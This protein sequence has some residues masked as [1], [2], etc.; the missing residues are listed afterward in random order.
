M[1]NLASAR[2]LSPTENAHQAD[3]LVQ[4]FM[5]GE[6]G[7]AYTLS[8]RNGRFA[9]RAG[10]GKAMLLAGYR[11]AEKLGFSFHFHGEYPPAKPVDLRTVAFEE[12]RRPRFVRRGAQL[13]NFWYPG[14]D[15]W[16]LEDYRDYLDQFPKLGLNHLD[17]PLYLYEPLYT[18]Y[19]FRDAVQ[20]GH[21]LSGWRTDAVR[22]GSHWFDRA[23]RFSSPDVPVFGEFEARS[24]AMIRLT[25]RIFDHAESR[26]VDVSLGIEL[27]QPLLGAH[28]PIDTSVLEKIPATDRYCGGSLL[29]PSSATGKEF[30]EARL[31]ALIEAYPKC[32]LISVWKPEIASYT[33]GEVSPHPEDEGLRKK[34][35]GFGV[36]LSDTD[37]DFLC[38]VHV[39]HGVLRRLAPNARMMLSGWGV[40][41]LLEFAD[42]TL[43]TDMI[44]H[45]ID[46][47]EAKWTVERNRLDNYGHTK[48]SKWHTTWA[49][50]D[51]QMWLTQMKTRSIGRLLDGLEAHDVEGVM[52][53]HWR[54][55]HCDLN[56]TFLARRCWDSGLMPE[57]HWR[58]WTEEK[59]G[60]GGAEHIVAALERLE[61]FAEQAVEGEALPFPPDRPATLGK[62]PGTWIVGQDCVLNGIYLIY[63]LYERG[64][65]FSEAALTFFVHNTRRGLERIVPHLETA[66]DHLGAAQSEIEDTGPRR[67]RF[68]F[69]RNRIDFTLR[70][71]RFHYAFTFIAERIDDALHALKSGDAQGYRS[72]S[73]ESLAM[74]RAQDVDGLIS[75]FAELMS[76]SPGQ[77]DLGELGLLLGLNQKLL[78]IL[79]Q[80]R[81]SLEAAIGER[82]PKLE[83]ELRDSL[84]CIRCA[85]NVAEV[86]D[87]GEGT[88][89]IPWHSLGLITGKEGAPWQPGH[90]QARVAAGFGYAP[91]AG[92]RSWGLTE[93]RTCWL[94]SNVMSIDIQT[95]KDFSGRLRLH[96][97][98]ML[99]YTSMFLAQKVFVN[100]THR[101]TLSDCSHY[102]EFADQ[103][104]WIDLP[105]AAEDGAINIR[106][107]NDGGQAVQGFTKVSALQ[108]VE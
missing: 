71:C 11:L 86:N 74:L 51:Q 108:L 18:N 44:R 53:V 46:L 34:W 10:S 27:G 100:G 65:P 15:S 4:S 56:A 88:Y 37:L 54:R 77:G 72:L 104:R 73:A 85:A 1:M 81:G 98:D 42:S 41:H 106:I 83:G 105:V 102:G 22:I 29:M 38:W 68:T 32:R 49:E 89:F 60:A 101:C 14:R 2:A 35:S 64:E 99:G 45:S 39:A 59:F 20:F 70:Y 80:L 79:L 78:D 57:Q 40:E 47:Y 33:A 24:D 28:S 67:D 75:H 66:C 63:M 5:S 13:W 97:H 7:D 96:F 19:A 95:P 17:I 12:S 90:D 82:S 103:G 61:D 91:G 87:D 76:E 107:E 23:G 30:V 52:M 43:P 3:V 36:R 31:R 25:R 50:S 62:M 9:I 48:G 84:L 6:S 21:R 55:L 94:G 69:F 16:S 92:C 58:N 8:A 26:G 93:R